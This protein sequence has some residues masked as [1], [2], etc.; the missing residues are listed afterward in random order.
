LG[1]NSF[2]G[3]ECS[4]DGVREH[5]DDRIFSDEVDMNE[6]EKQAFMDYADELER[7]KQPSFNTSPWAV[8][9]SINLEGWIEQLV[10]RIR[11]EASK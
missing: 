2:P 1:D 9:L 10:D 6:K 7:L 3:R 5:R 11:S 4:G 8:V